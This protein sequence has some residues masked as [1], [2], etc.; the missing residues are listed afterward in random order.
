MPDAEKPRE[1]MLQNGPQ[2]LSTTELVAIILN[3]GT[4]KED[5]L[6]LAARI[7]KEYG[8]RTLFEYANPAQ[9]AADLDIPLLKAMKIAACGEL[10]RRF[11]QKKHAG[12]TVLRTS[13]DVYDYAYDMH[14]LSKEHLRGLYLNMHYQVIH[15]EVLS[16]GT[17]GSNLIHPRELFRP[18]LE[19]NAAGLILVHNHPSDVV[20]PSQADITVTRQLIQAGIIMGINLI[21]HVIITKDAFMSVEVD[22][23]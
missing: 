19:Y 22:Y 15:D 20:T 16:I 10:G 23:E 13:H 11:F 2:A 1:K 6:S 14:R 7:V 5:V 21:D 4:K 3:S 17:V 9:I 12:G 18:A 8:E